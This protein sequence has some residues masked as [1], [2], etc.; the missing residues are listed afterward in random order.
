MSGK[1]VPMINDHQPYWLKNTFGKF[2]RWYTE[3]FV[4]PHL[5]S[6]GSGH[7]MMKPWNVQVH[8]R[9]ITIGQ[10]VHIVSDKDRNVSFSTWA[11]AEHQGHI[12]LGDNVLVCPGC[13]FDS[14]SSI[15]VG[16]NCMFAAGAYITDA[17]WHDVYDRTEVVGVTKP[18]KL[19]KNVWIGDGATVCKGVTIGEN[20]VIGAGSLVASDI[21]ANVIA[22]GNPAKVIKPLDPDK[23]LVTRETL[24]TDPAALARQTD[25][26]NRYVLTSNSFFH[27]IRTIFFPKRGD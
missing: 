7:N 10:N 20:S 15:E 11:I 6:L 1:A 23:E 22:A 21:P 24:F 18:V 9:H 27:W 2:E 19:G 13:R 4:S 17:D 14:A 26:I 25:A 5:E 12:T 16:D 3:H 8:G